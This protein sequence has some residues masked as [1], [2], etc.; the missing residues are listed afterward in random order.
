MAGSTWGWAQVAA[1]SF[2]VAAIKPNVSGGQGH[3]VGFLGGGRLIEK[4]ATV[5]DLIVDAY[6]LRMSASEIEGLVSG[7]PAWTGRDRFDI[8]AKGEQ[9]T[10]EKLEHAALQRLLAERFKL[11]LH[12]EARELP[13][14]ALTVAKGGPKLTPWTPP[15]KPVEPKEPTY[16]LGAMVP[17]QSADHWRGFRPGRGRLRAMQATMTMLVGSLQFYPETA[18]LMVIDRTGLTGEYNF[19]LEWLPELEEQ[20]MKESAMAPPEASW[21]GLFT[22]LQ[23][24][25]GLKLELSKGPV[26][27]I[28]ID[29]VE[30]P[31]AN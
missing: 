2:D 6:G 4:N 29:S 11:K 24:E 22:A 12:H 8:E 5:K 23:D 16:A 26:D 15:P 14:Y 20:R 21:P 31:S 13:V 25:L 17:T 1:P 7:G 3:G 19:L 27:T 10:S 9:L 30:M 28:V 18:G